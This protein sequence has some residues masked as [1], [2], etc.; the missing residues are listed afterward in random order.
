MEDV[1]IL[2]E[3]YGAWGLAT[4]V[5]NS[6]HHPPT[7]QHR[8]VRFSPLAEVIEVGY[9]SPWLP[10][11]AQAGPGPHRTET[12]TTTM[13]PSRAVAGVAPRR[14]MSKGNAGQRAGG[15]GGG[16]HA[17]GAVVRPS[18]SFDAARKGVD[19]AGLW[20]TPS[21]MRGLKL[22]NLSEWSY[23]LE[24]C[25]GWRG[26]PEELDMARCP[27]CFSAIHPV[28]RIN[29]GSGVECDDCFRF[30]ERRS[31]PRL[32]KRNLRHLLAAK[33]ELELL[34]RRALTERE[35]RS[36]LPR[37]RL[38]LWQRA[39]A[40][41][42]GVVLSEVSPAWFG[43]YSGDVLEDDDDL[44]FEDYISSTGQ[45]DTKSRWS[46]MFASL[47]SGS[48]R[49]GR[50]ALVLKKLRSGGSIS[51]SSAVDTGGGGSGYG[52][53]GN[54]DHAPGNGASRAGGF[55]SAR[56]SLGR[57][58][59]SAEPRT[60]SGSQSNSRSNS[61]NNSLTTTPRRP[62]IPRPK[63]LAARS[64]FNT[65]T[66]SSTP[67]PASQPPESPLPGLPHPRPSSSSSPLFSSSSSSSS[68]YSRW[69]R[70]ASLG[71]EDAA[72]VAHD[73]PRRTGHHASIDRPPTAAAAAVAA[74]VV[75]VVIAEEAPR[76]PV[77]IER[78]RRGAS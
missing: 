16:G 53:G 1:N 34:R 35:R 74:A 69:T 20:W 76:T 27:V 4:L 18:A 30:R 17:G 58:S 54:V 5:H 57:G 6:T 49:D 33:A 24:V 28:H 65:A 60:S 70:A 47:R 3:A 12:V 38:P 41:A 31:L 72:A 14:Y 37:P 10:A 61:R 46:N 32:K 56:G 39:F 59:D 48:L 7:P 25:G 50:T 42:T 75:A 66:P 11:P 78:S 22:M 43:D 36:A 71:A 8:M 29:H 55:G 26:A 19:E 63:P 64:V 2:L 45:P 23:E 77:F 44:Y 13:G 51:R 15:G 52:A 73:Q 21:E 62:S 40:A 67:P 9:L 68:S